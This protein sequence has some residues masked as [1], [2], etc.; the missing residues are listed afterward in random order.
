MRVLS[1]SLAARHAAPSRF[2]RRCTMAPDDATSQGHVLRATRRWFEQFV[3]GLALCPF[4]QPPH[5]ANTIRYALSP[6]TSSAELLDGLAEELDLL[7]RTDAIETTLLVH[8]SV[9]ADSWDAHAAWLRDVDEAMEQ[10]RLDAVFQ[11]VGFHPQHVCAGE[12]ASNTAHW[13]NRSPYPLTH[14]LR[15]SSVTDAVDSFPDVGEVPFA[16]QRKLSRL[17]RT[18]LERAIHGEDL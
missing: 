7:Q 9:H 2:A 5:E 8:P 4:A 12:D 3:L 13:S 16:N 11:L 18:D 17:S 14:I 1:S 6:A 10:S 15:Q